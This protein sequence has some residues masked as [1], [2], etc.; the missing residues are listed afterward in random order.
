MHDASVG[1]GL[2]CKVVGTASGKQLDV[3]VNGYAF[4]PGRAVVQ[5]STSFTGKA[6][7]N[8]QLT[9]EIGLRIRSE[10]SR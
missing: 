8:I 5:F 3:T 2:Q 9:I 1:A 10:T 6:P 7:L 4:V